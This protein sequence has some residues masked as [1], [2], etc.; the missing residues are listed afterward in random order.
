MEYEYVRNDK[1]YNIT[2]TLK[3]ADG[4]VADLTDVTVI[5]INAAAVGAAALKFT[6]TCVRSSPYTAGICTYTVQQ[7][8]TDTVGIYHAELQLTY[9]GGKIFTTDRFDMNVVKDLP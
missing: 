7:T 8:D 5:T 2:F 3:N 4:T 6:G 1:L 9:S